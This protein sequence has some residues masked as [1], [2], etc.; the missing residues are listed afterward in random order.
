M[1]SN[2]YTKPFIS[3]SPQDFSNSAIE[4]NNEDSANMYHPEIFQSHEEEATSEVER[5]ELCNF[6][7]SSH[8]IVV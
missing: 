1:A 6:K 5:S 7:A 3:P 8:Y 2:D 4:T